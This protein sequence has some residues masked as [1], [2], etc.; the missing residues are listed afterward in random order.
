MH[1]LT[2]ALLAT[3]FGAA[4]FAGTAYSQALHPASAHPGLLAAA[5]A[6]ALADDDDDQGDEGGHGRGNPHSCV[7]PA[8][9]ERGWCKNG[10][11]Q[12]RY[13][14]SYGGNYTTI[15]GTVVA[16]NGDL[17]QFHRDNGSMA[18][19][20]QGSLLNNGMGLNT[21]GHYTLRGYWSNNLF[22]AQPNGGYYGNNNNN[23]GYPYPGNGNANSSVRGVITAVSG[24]HVT[25][26][27]GLFSSITIDDQQALNNGS[28]QNLYVGRSITAYGFWSGNLFYATSIG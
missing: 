10:R 23:N 5:P 13:N 21:G 11:G 4:S 20:N 17:V 7:N 3:L 16:V 8:G 25:I 18:T 27:Q 14:G 15:S 9:H 24:N 6:V 22:I 1:K 26:M 19:V 12:N 2:T 28:A